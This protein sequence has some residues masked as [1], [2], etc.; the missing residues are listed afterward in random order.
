MSEQDYCDNCGQRF[1][2]NAYGMVLA[3]RSRGYQM[4]CG[5]CLELESVSNGCEE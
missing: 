4:L 2:T 1:P 3:L 5:A